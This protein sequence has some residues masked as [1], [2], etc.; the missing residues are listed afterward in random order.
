MHPV[1][2]YLGP[3]R[4]ILTIREPQATR[5]EEQKGQKEARAASMHGGKA[6]TPQKIVYS[7]DL[8]EMSV[9]IRQFS[10]QAQNCVYLLQL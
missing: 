4:E 3:Y 10:F 9:E 1:K 8:R 7:R 6:L 5:L 2:D